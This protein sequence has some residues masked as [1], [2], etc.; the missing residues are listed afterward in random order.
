MDQILQKILLQLRPYDLH[1]VLQCKIVREILKKYNKNYTIKRGFLCTDEFGAPACITYFWLETEDGSK[2]D[3]IKGIRNTK[4]K[5]FLT[6]EKLVG[7]EC[8]DDWEPEVTRENDM[9]WKSIQSNQNIQATL[10]IVEK[11]HPIKI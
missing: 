11:S 3:V 9:L 10:N 4:E 7:I 1:P 6:E 5:Y 8:I 2:L